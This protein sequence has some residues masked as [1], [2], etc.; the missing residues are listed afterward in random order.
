MP[1]LYLVRHGRATSGWGLEADPGLDESG[2][3]QAEASARKMAPV[4][5]LP[6]IASPLRRAREN[7]AAT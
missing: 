4:G 3:L 1:K 5:P 2:H 7:G 6:I